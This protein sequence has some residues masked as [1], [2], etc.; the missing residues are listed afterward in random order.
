MR[1]NLVALDFPENGYTPDYVEIRDKSFHLER[2]VI[3]NHHF[4]R[5]EFSRCTF[6]HSG[7]P[8]AFG[9][10]KIDGYTRLVLTGP[11]RRGEVLRETTVNNPERPTGPF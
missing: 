11:A 5:C 3:D 1:L 10:C 7:G 9:E 2:L 4:V 6:V 8:F